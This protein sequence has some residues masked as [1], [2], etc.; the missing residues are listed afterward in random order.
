MQDRLT[1][2]PVAKR[3]EPGQQILPHLLAILLRSSNSSIPFRDLA[4]TSNFSIQSTG[5]W[6]LK[7]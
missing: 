6:R 5:I 4:S 1:L 7:R 3:R 2:P